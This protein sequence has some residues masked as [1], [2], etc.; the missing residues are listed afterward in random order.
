MNSALTHKIQLSAPRILTF[1]S[2]KNNVDA[3]SLKKLSCELITEGV[4]KTQK[5][6]TYYN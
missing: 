3:R 2:E 6:E 4:I 5:S 1:S